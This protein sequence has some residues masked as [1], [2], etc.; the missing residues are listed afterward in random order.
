[1][2]SEILEMIGNERVSIAYHDSN[3]G[4]IEGWWRSADMILHLHQ[5]GMSLALPNW[6]ETSEGYALMHLL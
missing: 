5:Y 6:S 3:Y 2:C 4:G 1:M